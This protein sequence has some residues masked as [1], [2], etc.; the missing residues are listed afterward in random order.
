MLR[1]HN[2]KMMDMPPTQTRFSE[3]IAAFLRRYRLRLP[4]LIL[5]DAGRPLTFFGGQLLW[6]SQPL[7]SLFGKS[8][9]VARMARL[10]EEPQAVA[11]LI[12]QLEEIEEG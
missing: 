8:T 3:E 4:A 10:L 12:Q 11:Q 9:Q 5:L 7:F 1:Q 2:Q 6:V